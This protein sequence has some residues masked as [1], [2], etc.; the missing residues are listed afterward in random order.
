[1]FDFSFQ[2][3]VEIRSIE[4]PNDHNDHY[5]ATKNQSFF[6]GNGGLKSSAGIRT[7]TPSFS[8][9]LISHEADQA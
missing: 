3:G 6:V 5:A 7:Q 8:E 9:F 2:A 1:M 4:T